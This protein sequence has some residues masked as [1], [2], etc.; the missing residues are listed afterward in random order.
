MYLIKIIKTLE[1]DGII[2]YIVQGNQHLKLNTILEKKLKNSYTVC[3]LNFRGNNY[4][5]LKLFQFSFSSKF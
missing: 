4:E 1:S 3:S 5:I 2:S